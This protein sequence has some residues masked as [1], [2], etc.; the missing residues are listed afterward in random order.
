M[1][2]R[3]VKSHISIRSVTNAAVK[4]PQEDRMRSQIVQLNGTVAI[5]DGRPR[6]SVYTTTRGYN[7][8]SFVSSLPSI[9]LIH[10][11]NLTAQYTLTP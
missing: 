3:I 8:R 9:I 10:K 5:A 4:K 1:S 2:L 7:Y 11:K 6:Q